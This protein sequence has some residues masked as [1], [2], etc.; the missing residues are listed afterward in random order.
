[1]AQAF[2]RGAVRLKLPQVRV[3]ALVVDDPQG[4]RHGLPARDRDHRGPDRLLAGEIQE[5]AEPRDAREKN[6]HRR[7]NHA[8]R[9]AE[10][11]RCLIACTADPAAWPV[12]AR[13]TALARLG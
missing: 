10:L 3:V 5:R 1:M 6:D 8:C 12:V 4:Q 2:F 9:L 13:P 7:R 11:E